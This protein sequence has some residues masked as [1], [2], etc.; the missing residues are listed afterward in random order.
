MFPDYFIGWQK[1]WSLLVTLVI[2]SILFHVTSF[3]FILSGWMSVVFWQYQCTDGPRRQ[4]LACVKL[5]LSL[6][7]NGK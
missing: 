5:L 3:L 4:D 1:F 2:A 7:L 6:G